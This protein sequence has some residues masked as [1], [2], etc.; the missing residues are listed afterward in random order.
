MLLRFVARRLV[1]LLLI[2]LAL[3]GCNGGPASTDRPLPSEFAVRA[4]PPYIRGEI[5]A[6]TV[7]ENGTIRLRVRAPA[8]ADARVP[9]AIVTLASNA[10]VRWEHGHHADADLLVRGRKVTVW[11]TG[12]E[13]R[14][15]PPQ[16]T[17]NGFLLHYW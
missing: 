1:V 5:I 8:G 9:E 7:H 17:G 10:I 12:P 11:I 14:S 4:D 2:P 3:A 13:L 15:L 16:V 6:R